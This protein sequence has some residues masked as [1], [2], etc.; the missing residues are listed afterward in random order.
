MSSRPAH[1]RL[2]PGRPPPPERPDRGGEAP[3]GESARVGRAGSPSLSGQPPRLDQ[4]AGT[5]SSNA[6]PAERYAATFAAT[7]AGVST[8]SLTCST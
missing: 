3:P 2:W 7:W 4:L 1:G 8:W 5:V 6:V